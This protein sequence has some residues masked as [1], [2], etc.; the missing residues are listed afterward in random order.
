[1]A[2][3]DKEEPWDI[4]WEDVLDSSSVSHAGFFSRYLAFRIDGLVC[5]LLISL[6][7][8]IITVFYL[9]GV[10]LVFGIL[11]ALIFPEILYFSLLEWKW[12]TIGKSFAG[13]EVVDRDK[14]SIGF[15][16]ALIRN[17]ERVIWMIPLLGQLFLYMSISSIKDAGVRFGDDWAETY[18]IEKGSDFDSKQRKPAGKINSGDMLGRF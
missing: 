18:V 8:F 9:R 7:I 17:S 13:I 4:E 5:G 12:N 3:E 2:G 15:K 10:F 11:A 14:K 16:Q 6:P 1:M